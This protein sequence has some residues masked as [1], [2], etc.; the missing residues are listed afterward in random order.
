MTVTP[1]LIIAWRFFEISSVPLA[2][3]SGHMQDFTRRANAAAAISGG[4][5]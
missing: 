3:R 5:P 2:E 1:S 4:T